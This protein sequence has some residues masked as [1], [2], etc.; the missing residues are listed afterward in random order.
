M[1]LK[2]IALIFIGLFFLIIGSCSAQEKNPKVVLI[3]LDGLRWQELFSGA[4]P[5][6]VANKE[7]VHDTT[8]LKQHFWRDSPTERREALFPFLWKEASKMGQIHGNRNLGNKVNL[9]NKMWFS[10]PGYNEIL[11]GIADDSRIYSNDKVNNPN[12]TVLEIANQDIR[13]KDKVAAFGSWDVFPYIVNEE[14]SGVPV[15]AGFELAKGNDL[16]EREKLLNELQPKT[17]SPWGTVRFDAFTHNYLLEHM[18]KSHPELIYI[19][20][21]ETDDFAH[22]GDY[23]AYLKSAS[24]TDAMIKELWNFTQE[25]EFYK[26]N[27][28]FIITTDHGRGTD[29]IDTWRNHGDSVKNAG[30]VW[31]ILFGKGVTFEG[32]VSSQEQLYSNQLAPTILKALNLQIDSKKMQGQPLNSISKN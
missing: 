11:S 20:Y 18:K 16:T 29:P 21:G 24:T 27:T 2:F 5:L 15:N 32:E 13:Y 19:A 22:D 25:D 26:D 1:K 23:E 8:G 12:T 9:T 7:Y 4:D 3:T 17:P 6:L 31:M 10:Y 28:L 30:E 14:R